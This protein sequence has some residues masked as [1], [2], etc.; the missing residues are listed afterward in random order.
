MDSGASAKGFWGL[1]VFSREGCLPAQD[2]A[3]LIPLKAGRK[4]LGRGLLASSLKD[5]IQVK[6]D[7]A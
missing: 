5:Q 3:V 2:T 4:R 6:P 1:D 7:G